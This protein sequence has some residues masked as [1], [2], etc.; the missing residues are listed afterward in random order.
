SAYPNRQTNRDY[1]LEYWKYISDQ[2][3]NPTEGT[4]HAMIFGPKGQRVQIIMLDL[5]FYATAWTESSENSLQFKK[6]WKASATLLGNQQWHWLSRELQKPADFRIIVSPLQVGANSLA[7]NR[8]GLLPLER[9]KLFDTLRS[10]HAKNAVVIS[11]NRNFAAFSKVDLKNFRPLYDMT[12][13]PLNGE[14]STPDQDFHYVEN[15]LQGHNFG[16]VDLD[17]K[18]RTATLQLVDGQNNVVQS[19]PLKF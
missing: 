16:M 17:W 6:N 15:P 3:K 19:L 10:A 7:S 14:T 4:E 12:V 9:Q 13:G 5:R 11:G 18:K 2:Q 8:W 1:F